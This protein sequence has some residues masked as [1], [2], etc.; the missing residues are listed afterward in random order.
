MY[1]MYHMI[2]KSVTDYKYVLIFTVTLSE[3][4]RIVRKT[5]RDMM[6]NVYWSS[7]RV[8]AILARF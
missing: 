8:A 6:K 7:C 3:E 2:L 1:H 4:F 5:E